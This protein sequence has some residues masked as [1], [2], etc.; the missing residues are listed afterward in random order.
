MV[1]SVQITVPEPLRFLT[2]EGEV[3]GDLPDFAHDRDCLVSMYR[4][5]MLTRTFDTKAIALQRTGRLGT[6]GSSLGQEAIGIG[7]AL[8]MRDEDVF[9]PSFREH[10]A[11]M[12][13]GVSLEELFLFWAGDE[14]GNAFAEQAQDFPV[15][16]PVASHFPHAA[17][18]ALAMAQRS[19]AR[20]AVAVAGDGAT[21]KGDFY[22]A[23][24]LVGVWRLP[25]VFVIN[26]NQWAISVR[27][28]DQSAAQTLAQKAVAAGVPGKVVDGNDVIAVRTAVAEAL[29][30]ARVGKGG[31][32]IE[33]Q[34][35]RL[36]DHTTADDA[37]R[38]RDDAEVS[39]HWQEE[40]IARLRNYLVAHHG[41]SREEEKALLHES[42]TCV[43]AAAEAYLTIEP[44]PARAMFD[45]LFAELPAN[46]A[47]QAEEVADG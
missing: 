3:V 8:A 26:N 40:P 35:Y 12:L 21:S 24:N 9:L 27:R 2:P 14:R 22:E 34:T 29:D 36:G 46:L 23:L 4:A 31:S 5:M 38:Y 11:Q 1:D 43:N 33:C 7:T 39:P 47:F 41:W 18:V 6:Y 44:E 42:D 16:I 17:G 13:R 30:N 19:E 32:L 45:H 37:S 28:S 25:A 15:C 20:V 10:G